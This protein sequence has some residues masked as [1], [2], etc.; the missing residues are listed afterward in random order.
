MYK[1]TIAK[2]CAYL[3]KKSRPERPKHKNMETEEKAMTK[4][5][6]NAIN[7]VLIRPVWLAWKDSF[8]TYDWF[9]A[10]PVPELAMREVKELM[11]LAQ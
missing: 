3:S 6:N 5:N 1:L 4:T 7:E 2:L 11:L 9:K 8:R 10:I